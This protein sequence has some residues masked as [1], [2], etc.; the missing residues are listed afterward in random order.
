MT[1]PVAALPIVGSPEGAAETL[2][3]NALAEIQSILR[4]GL[5]ASNIKDDSITRAK[6]AG[7]VQSILLPPGIVT[8]TFADTADAGWLLCDGSLVSTTI[9][10][11]LFQRIQHKGN[12]V[13]GLPVDP[14]NGQ[15]RLPDLRGRVPVGADGAANR[16][17]ANDT[18]G[19]SSGAQKVALGAGNLPQFAVTG[20]ATS[21]TDIAIDNT[22][23]AFYTITVKDTLA[24]PFSVMPPN[25]VGNYQI[26]T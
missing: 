12:I 24:T 23:S 16:L 18:V 14:G 4:G 15:F 25:Q 7:A 11:A 3:T 2:V 8:W 13:N 26:K 10:N 22:M 20:D 9:Y 21:G 6:L 1:Q 19:A 17:D 5:D